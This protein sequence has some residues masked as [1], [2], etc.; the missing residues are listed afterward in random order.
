MNYDNFDITP[1]LVSEYTEMVRR[2]VKKYYTRLLA[3][4]R[5]PSSG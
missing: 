2:I 1:E 3:T 4:P 5:T